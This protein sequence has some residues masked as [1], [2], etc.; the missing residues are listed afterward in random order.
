MLRS[1]F[2]LSEK[3]LE[4]QIISSEG[5][6]YIHSALEKGY[7]AGSYQSTV[8]S[9]FVDRLASAL[10]TTSV[11]TQNSSTTDEKASVKLE[12]LQVNPRSAIG[13]L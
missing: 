8:L 5:V 11:E 2:I 9:L 12:S 7:F 6:A 10:T 4:G 13:N 1:G 3:Q